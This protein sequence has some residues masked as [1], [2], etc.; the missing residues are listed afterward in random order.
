MFHHPVHG[1]AYP[2]GTINDTVVEICR[3]AGIYYARTTVSTEKFDM[4]S[5]WLRLPA[6]CHHKN[7]RLTELCDQ[8]LSKDVKGKPQL[9][10]LWGH[11]YEFEGD[12]NWSIIEEFAAKMGQHKEIWYATNM[13]IYLAQ[14]DFDR[15][16]FS[17]D[18]NIAYNPNARTVCFADKNGVIYSI[19]PGETL[20]IQ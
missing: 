13:E 9:F 6:T 14:R 11:S 17:A 12:N 1:M 5:D 3:L 15:L 7:P 20:H 10:Y 19:V 2:Y 8:F 16:E 4:P 18:G